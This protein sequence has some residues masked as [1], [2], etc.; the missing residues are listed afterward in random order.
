MCIISELL[1]TINN[2]HNSDACRSQSI[3]GMNDNG[4][5]A[6]AQ[7]HQIHKPMLAQSKFPRQII[8]ARVANFLSHASIWKRKLCFMGNAQWND[9]A[10][11]L[12]FF[13]YNDLPTSRT[14]HTRN[15]TSIVLRCIYEHNNTNAFSEHN[16]FQ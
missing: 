11:Q 1:G 4:L 15:A 8:R 13:R 10:I 9:R 12:D 2:Q 7:T 6:S 14:L 5:L 3:L 16:H